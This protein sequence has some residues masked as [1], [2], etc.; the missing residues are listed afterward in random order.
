MPETM[1]PI[2]PFDFEEWEA[3]AKAKLAVGPFGYIAGGA[4][5]GS[6]M[7]ENRA[8]FDRWQIW[9]RMLRD[10][11]ERNISVKLFGTES[12]G[13]LLLA[14]VAA[15]GTMHAQAERATARA[16][17]S[18]GVPMVLSTMASTP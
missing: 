5:S 8:A 4:G 2:L 17:R 1:T 13:P 9:P 7:R 15:Q 10:V 16:A 14:P 3:A 12:A 18:A 6:T 11:S